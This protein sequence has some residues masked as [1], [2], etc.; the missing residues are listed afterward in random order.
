MSIILQ[1]QPPEAFCKKKCSYKFRKIHT[2]TP[3]PGSLFTATLLKKRLGH[4]CFPVNFANFQEH[5]FYRTPP[6]D[7]FCY[8]LE[9]SE[10]ILCKGSKIQPFLKLYT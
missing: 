3:A 1:K 10:T 9:T 8:F 7:C 6:G 4:R 5:L 2:E